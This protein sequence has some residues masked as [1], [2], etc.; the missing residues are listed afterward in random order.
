MTT[1]K[2]KPAI[3]YSRFSSTKQQHGIS[4]ERQNDA[5]HAYIRHEGLNLLMEGTWSDQGVSAYKGKH[6]EEGE[7]GRLLDLLQARKLPEGIVLVVENLDRLSRETPLDALELVTDIVR[8]GA[9]IATVHDSQVYSKAEF[10]RNPSSLFLLVAHMQRANS[11]SEARSKRSIASCE[12]KRK[13]QA[14][15]KVTKGRKS[16]WINSDGSLKP[17]QVKLIKGMV[18]Q[19][20]SGDGY[21]QIAKRLNKTGIPTPSGRGAWQQGVIARLLKNPQLLGLVGANKLYP[22][23]IDQQTFKQIQ[24]LS[25]GRRGGGH[26]SKTFSSATRGILVCGECGGSMQVIRSGLGKR[27]VRCRKAFSDGCDNKGGVSYR[28]STLFAV[29]EARMKILE[30]AAEEHIEDVESTTQVELEQVEKQIQRLIKLASMTDDNINQISDE[31]RRLK[32]QQDTLRHQTSIEAQRSELTAFDEIVNLDQELTEH[33]T[34]ALEGDGGIAASE[35]INRLLRRAQVELKLEK[36]NG[37]QGISSGS[38]WACVTGGAN[39][40]VF[41]EEGQEVGVFK[42]TDDGTEEMGAGYWYLDKPKTS[43]LK[44]ANN[45]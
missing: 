32:D 14:Q 1:L 43:N 8:T 20:L 22:A 17:E 16:F 44:S 31:I 10:D 6:R 23:A 21:I 30:R 33:V 5:A 28:L 15:G 40:T 41:D 9:S 42:R 37:K 2:G 25:E 3:I 7:L 19:Y 45:L 26:A 38:H 12:K 4:I 35:E 29:K 24:E 34:A 13:L 18:D 36:R 39:M 27:T 11:E